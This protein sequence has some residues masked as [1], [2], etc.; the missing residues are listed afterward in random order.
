[1]TEQQLHHFVSLSGRLARAPRMQIGLDTVIKV[2]AVDYS[3]WRLA[4][5]RIE[6]WQGQRW[7]SELDE[8][9]ELA[10]SR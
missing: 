8:L 4:V 9:F 10:M 2:P 5:S 6:T 1:M 3:E 7:S